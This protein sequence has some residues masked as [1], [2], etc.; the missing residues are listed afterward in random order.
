MS[1]S[2]DYPD[3][4]ELMEGVTMTFEPQVRIVKIR[5][6]PDDDIFRVPS[7]WHEDHDEIMTIY[8]G[9]LKITLGGQTKVY[10]PESGEV[11]IPRGVPHSIESFTAY[12]K[13]L[14]GLTDADASGESDRAG[15]SSIDIV[16]LS[17]LITLCYL[18]PLPPRKIVV[19][20]LLAI[21]TSAVTAVD[22]EIGVRYVDCQGPW[23]GSRLT[24]K[25]PFLDVATAAGAR[26]YPRPRMRPFS[27][28]YCI[29]FIK[30]MPAI[31]TVFLYMISESEPHTLHNELGWPEK[32]EVRD[33]LLLERVEVE[34]AKGLDRLEQNLAERTL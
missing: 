3:S 9:R 32:F 20:R 30:P 16:I 11:F 18:H 33:Q 12:S 7:H 13:N 4:F 19:E 15:R 22:F 31:C 8:E 10:T 27:H 23:V 28:R 26:D 25:S 14:V 34:E 29:Y 17:G 2:Q 5:G 6:A 21:F 1:K 24:P